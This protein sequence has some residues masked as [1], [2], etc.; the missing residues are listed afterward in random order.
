[1]N[2][3]PGTP[4][5]L[6]P[7][8]PLHEPGDNSAPLGDRRPPPPPIRP[9]PTPLPRPEDERPDNVAAD[10]GSCCRCQ[11][12]TARRGLGEGGGAGRG[13]GRGGGSTGRGA[14]TGG[15][16]GRGRGELEQ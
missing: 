4:N 2:S 11:V 7:P 14:R 13:G 6:P 16:P 8:V 1:M 15:R 12:G 10:C 3:E 5:G 9:L